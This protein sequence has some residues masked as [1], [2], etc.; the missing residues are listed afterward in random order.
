MAKEYIS[1][2]EVKEKLWMQGAVKHPGSFTAYCKR[3]GYKD[4]TEECIR[5]G[6]RSKDPT[7]RKRA[8]LA[9]TFR[10]YGGRK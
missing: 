8:S 9:R 1:K 4:V 3:Q 7:T 10:R 2:S 5:E 6:M